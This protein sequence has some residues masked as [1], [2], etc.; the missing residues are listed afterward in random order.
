VMLV[1]WAFLA[2]VWGGLSLR[3]VP[4]SNLIGGGWPRL[5]SFFR[6]LGFGVAFILIASAVSAGLGYL[7]KANMPPS[8][9]AMMPHALGDALAWVM[10]SCTAGFCEEIIFRGYFGRQ[11]AALT[12]SAAAGIILQG[13][14][15]GLGHGYQGWK[16]M[17]SLS[18]YG[19]LLGV[20]A[21]WRRSL[22]PGILAHA[23]QD[24]ASGL[25]W[26]FLN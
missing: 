8:V 23:L 12:G 21:H 9:G 19:S 6:D 15:F 18:I 26:Y 3:G 16:L 13:I 20:L 10:L 11:F 22:R 24:S 4:M 1:E 2:L 14:V 5:A 25:L 17:L 7:I